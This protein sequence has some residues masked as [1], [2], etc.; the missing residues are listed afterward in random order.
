MLHW[1]INH[2]S[3]NTSGKDCNT[4]IWM[5]SC[6]TVLKRRQNKPQTLTTV[7]MFKAFTNDHSSLSQKQTTIIT[8]R[9]CRRVWI[10]D[11]R[12]SRPTGTQ[13]QVVKCRIYPAIN[14]ILFNPN[15][16]T[17]LFTMHNTN[18]FVMYRQTFKTK[19]LKIRQRTRTSLAG[20][21]HRSGD[22]YKYDKGTSSINQ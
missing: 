6:N 11:S 12:L 18:P 13:T 17:H 5:C 14:I 15:P 2:F 21:H 3:T 20:M 4:N 16:F 22:P 1:S 9:T 8:Y 19:Q 7:L 10:S